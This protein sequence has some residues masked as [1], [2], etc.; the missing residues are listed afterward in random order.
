[1]ETKP[2][3]PSFTVSLR[4]YDRE[5]VD[6]YLDSL[7][8]ALQN[9]EDA[10]ERNRRLQVHAARLSSRVKD[11]EERI[12]MDTPKTGAVLGERIA[13]LL[14]AAEE[15]AAETINR[16]EVAA[17]E[18]NAEAEEKLAAVE[19]EVRTSIAQG[20]E[21][22][23]R[24]EAE[25]RTVATR[26]VGEAEARAAARTRQIEQ[27]AED[28]VART[29]DEDSRMHQEQQVRREAALAELAAL[30]IERDR[31]AATLAELRD[32]L[33]H[34]IGLAKESAQ[35]DRQTPSPK[36][37]PQEA[38]AT[39][40]GSAPS[41]TGGDDDRSAGHPATGDT[42]TT[43]ERSAA[44]EPAATVAKPS[45]SD[46]TPSAGQSY[47]TAWHPAV[48]FDDLMDPSG[49]TAKTEGSSPAAGDPGESGPG[50]GDPSESEDFDV[51]LEAWVSEG[52]K[53]FGQD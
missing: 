44:R 8:E 31:V 36:G 42:G 11:L 2:H 7:A 30:V 53:R 6:E 40:S 46:G 21:Q 35:V 10:E 45:T 9:V 17:A 3:P 15:T 14:G 37:T 23:R 19:E 51:K 52:D 1:M 29:R 24:I 26:I 39:G 41:A 28:V 25:A 22:G 47:A 32:S 50:P 18:K 27:W 12:R 34:S 16:A 38:G 43:G 4:G 5:Q 33:G 48:V 13:L 49:E 20:E